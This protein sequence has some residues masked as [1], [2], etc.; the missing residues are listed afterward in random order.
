[1][2]SFVNWLMEFL[3]LFVLPLGLYLLY[4]TCFADLRTSFEKASDQHGK[5]VK[6]IQKGE[7]AVALT[8]FQDLLSRG[9]APK[10]FVY[11][12][13]GCAHLNEGNSHQ[14]LYCFQQAV[15]FDGSIALA[16]KKSADLL[17]AQGAWEETLT[18]LNRALFY[19][20]TDANC[21]YLKAKCLLELKQRKQ[22]RES[23][24][25]AARCGSEEANFLLQNSMLF[26]GWASQMME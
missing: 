20:R 21:H 18:E 1:M 5:V 8:Y 11:F 25:E 19:L 3:L 14:A 13:L 2:L 4:L 24:L 6:S 10:G 26:K 12:Q 22:A 23:L 16:Y 9:K 7:G 17:F 15:R